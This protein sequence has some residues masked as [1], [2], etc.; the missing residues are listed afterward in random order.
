MSTIHHFKCKPFKD[1]TVTESFMARIAIVGGGFG[2]IWA[3]RNLRHHEIIFFEP[4][5]RFI[6]TPLLH[7]VAG[8]VLSEEDTT[9]TYT[10]LLK[11]DPRERKSNTH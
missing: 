2:G 3:L 5:D 4:K 10:K 1:S 6:F 9:I 11:C 8:G 7:E